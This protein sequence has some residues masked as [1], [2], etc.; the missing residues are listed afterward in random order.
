MAVQW[1]TEEQQRVWRTYLLGVA[2]LTEELDADLRRSGLDLPE[3]E[4]LVVLEES[5]DRRLRM[6]ELA[7]AV[8]QSRSRLTH[9]IARM[10]KTGL[11]ERETCPT[12][13]RGVWAQLT[14]T[15]YEMLRQTAPSH[16]KAV[17][18]FFVDA[19]DPEDYE[20]LGRAFAAVLAVD[21]DDDQ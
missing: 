16:V 10:E 14:E 19:V 11:V 7:D 15:G 18:R 13:R 8:H 9:T 12:D 6:S 17:R 3:Y 4:I 2:R 1:L 5:P 21:S 20:A